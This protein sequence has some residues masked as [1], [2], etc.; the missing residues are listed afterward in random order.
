MKETIVY[1]TRI[2]VLLL[3]LL[4]PALAQRGVISGVVLDPGGARI[5]QADIQLTHVSTN[6]KSHTASNDEG[7]FRFADLLPGEYRVAAAHTGFKESA[8]NILLNVEERK[9]VTFIL[10]LQDAID[11]ITVQSSVSPAHADGGAVSTV[12]SQELVHNIPVNGRSFQTLL[13]FTPGLVQTPVTNSDHGAFSVNGQR[14]N[15]NY[16]TVDGVSANVGVRATDSLVSQ[17]LN[18]SIMSSGMAGGSQ[19]VVSI[20]EVQEFRVQTSSFAPE[21]GRTPGAQIQVSTR[22]GSNSFHGTVYEYLRNSAMD[23]TDWFVNAKKLARPPLRQNDFGGTVGGPVVKDRLFFFGSV[24]SLH[25]VQPQTALQGVPTAQVRSTAGDSV[26]DLL[27][28]AY[29]LP[30]QDGPTDTSGLFAASYGNPTR[31]DIFSLRADYIIN[32][33]ASTFVR[34]S[35][36]PGTGRQGI[37]ISRYRYTGDNNTVTVGSTMSATPSITNDLRLNYSTAQRIYSPAPEWLSGARPLD[38]GKIIPAFDPATQYVVFTVSPYSALSDGTRADNRQRQYN[39]TDTVDK[40]IGRHQIRVGVDVRLLRPQVLTGSLTQVSFQNLTQLNSGIAASVLQLRTQGNTTVR[41]SNYSLFAQDVWSV[42][43][44][45]SITYGLRWELNP[46]PSD[47]NGG[48]PAI[49]GGLDDPASAKIEL[50]GQQP[51]KTQWDALAPRLGIAWAVK[52]TGPV[53]LT[54][55]GGTGMFYDLAPSGAVGSSGALSANVQATNVPLSSYSFALPSTISLPLST[56]FVADPGL[57]LPRTYEYNTTIDVTVLRENQVTVSYVGAMGRMLTRNHSYTGLTNPTTRYMAIFRDD[58][59]SDYNSLQVQYRRSAG[60]GFEGVASYTFGKSIDDASNQVTVPLDAQSDGRNERGLSDFDVRHQLTAGLVFHA[61]THHHSL[62]RAI[63][64]FLGGWTVSPVLRVRSGL[65]VTVL[66]NV[67]FTGN[68]YA[69]PRA[70]LVAGQPLWI[71]DI[72]APGGRKLNYYAF[73]NPPQNT[74]G[75]LGRNSIEGFGFA[76]VDLNIG[77]SFRLTERA[78]FQLSLDA[79]NVTN[80]PNFGPPASSLAGS[81][82]LFG[83]ASSLYSGS[84]GAGSING[85]L[86]P[87]Y[88]SGGPRSLQMSA[89]ISF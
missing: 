16:L 43:K 42:G 87:V 73:A 66:S 34:F 23:A 85:G 76:Q 78:T 11:S 36:S 46:P 82:T 88:Q 72:N 39:V 9:T 12:V 45:V 33:R 13:D 55:R 3:G 31:S 75:N 26:A 49:V 52:K 48:P 63:D 10:P 51:F 61:A 5:I 17:E 64:A 68:A 70:S 77:R 8:L 67:Q 58:G 14:A 25:L 83:I 44:G 50:T 35:H 80:H 60:R 37:G 54:L 22:G 81:S 19:G 15:A 38:V 32:E 41:Y 74:Q 30:N 24:E 20:D 1:L 6:Y 47:S 56:L 28:N 18:G 53:Q 84:L 69:T 62:G 40:L 71:N 4:T 79:F 57:R 27:L 89:R 7:L 65:P 59:T 29:P 86:N 21:F 2:T